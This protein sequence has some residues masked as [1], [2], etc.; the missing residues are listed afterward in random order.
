VQTGT[1]YTV[2]TSGATSDQGRTVVMA[3]TNAITLTLPN[4]APIG[5]SCDV[6]QR[7]PGQVTM[8]AASGAILRN[9][10]N[11]TKTRT[12]WSIVSL[13]VLANSNGTS[14]VW[15]LSGDTAA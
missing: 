6:M 3:N 13:K 7:D 1:A 11:H 14:A 9:A 12:A 10:S 4:N 15:Y 8:A 2:V 5:F